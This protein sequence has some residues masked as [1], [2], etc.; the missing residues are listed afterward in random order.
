MRDHYLEDISQF[1]DTLALPRYAIARDLMRLSEKEAV[2]LAALQGRDKCRTPMQW[3]GDKNG[4]FSPLGVTPWL[5]VASN[6]G[7]GVNVAAEEGDPHSMLAFYKRLLACRKAHPALQTGDFELDTNTPE[8]IV[9]Y[10]RV[11]EGEKITVIL[12]MSADTVKIKPLAQRRVLF[13]AN[14]QLDQPLNAEIELT[15]YAAFILQ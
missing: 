9:K 5:P 11:G 10:D 8:N 1:R 6:A 14:I 4:G 7:E 2:A 12:N 15:P 3:A 13:A